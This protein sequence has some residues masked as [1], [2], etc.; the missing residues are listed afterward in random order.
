MLTGTKNLTLKEINRIIKK[1]PRANGVGF[2]ITLSVFYLLYQI[3]YPNIKKIYFKMLKAKVG[4]QKIK[5]MKHLS[6][7]I[8]NNKKPNYFSFWNP[9]IKKLITI[10]NKNVFL[11]LY[12]AIK[13]LNKNAKSLPKHLR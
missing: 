4:E 6:K 9:K 11:N 2:V 5:T 12:S 8:C 10:S 13:Y 1:F 7:E 3:N